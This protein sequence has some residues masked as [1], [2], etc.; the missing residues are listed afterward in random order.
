[1]IRLLFQGPTTQ[2][3]K[4]SSFGQFCHFFGKKHHLKY[5]HMGGQTKRPD[6]TNSIVHAKYNW[7]VNGSPKWDFVHENLPKQPQLIN[8]WSFEC[9]ELVSQVFSQH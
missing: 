3:I 7:K 9:H 5:S 6:Q 1:M 2:V 8:F 4:F